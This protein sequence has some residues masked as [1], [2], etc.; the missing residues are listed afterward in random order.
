MKKT[1]LFLSLIGFASLLSSCVVDQYGYI[2]PAAPVVVAA[3]YYGPYWPF[4]GPYYG[5]FWEFNGMY[6]FNYHGRYCYYHNG[7]RMFAPLPPGAHYH[8][9][10]HSGH[11]GH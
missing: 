10:G 2:H 9:G 3:P 8:G 5:P 4:Y 11:G 7:H 1:L 6:Y